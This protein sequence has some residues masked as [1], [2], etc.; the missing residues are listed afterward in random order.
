LKTPERKLAATELEA[1]ALHDS[2]LHWECYLNNGRTFQVI[3]DH[4]A[5]VYMVTKPAGDPHQRLHRLCTDLQGYSFEIIHRKGEE[6]L[7]A[8]AISRLLQFGDDIYVNNA[9]DLRDDFGPLS[10]LDEELLQY[11]YP[12]D[13]KKVIEI[14]NRHRLERREEMARMEAADARAIAEKILKRRAAPVDDGDRIDTAIKRLAGKVKNTTIPNGDK[15]TGETA[16]PIKEETANPISFLNLSEETQRKLRGDDEDP[17][18]DQAVIINTQQ[19][20]RRSAQLAE[21]SHRRTAEALKRAEQKGREESIQLKL[22]DSIRNQVDTGQSTVDDAGKEY[23]SARARRKLEKQTKKQLISEIVWQKMENYGYLVGM[24]YE[25]DDGQLYIVINTF[26]DAKKQYWAT[27]KPQKESWDIPLGNPELKRRLIVGDDGVAYRVERL[28]KGMKQGSITKWPRT[29]D[30]WIQEQLND[31]GIPPIVSLLDQP[32]S[33]IRINGDKEATGDY[34]QRPVMDDG[35]A[36]ALRRY[37][38]GQAINFRVDNK[39]GH[40]TAT[41][42]NPLGPIFSFLSMKAWDI[43]D[44]IGRYR[45]FGRSIIGPTKPRTKLIMS[46]SVISANSV[47]PTSDDRPFPYRSILSWI[48]R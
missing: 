30:E 9:D 36:G 45:T 5:L 32:D 37:R 31:I 11:E 14:T 27:S 19:E 42:L 29:E 15:A 34:L 25:E 24:D 26:F 48:D 39:L 23:L 28:L 35:K 33:I 38:T 20:L 41:V 6:H 22:A 47:K 8:D 44:G 1:T 12:V 16:N 43:P 7:D 2:I 13:Y 3:S 17:F 4:Y 18:E 40:I 46:R 21:Q 10:P